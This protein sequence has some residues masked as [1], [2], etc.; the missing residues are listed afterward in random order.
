MALRVADYFGL[1]A[2]LIEQVDAST[3]SQPARRPA[4]TG[5]LIDKARRELGYQPHTFTEGIA[6]VAAQSDIKA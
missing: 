4:R 6:L 3:F 5:F 2:G 1:D